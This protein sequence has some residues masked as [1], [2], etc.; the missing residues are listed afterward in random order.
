MLPMA[1]PAASDV[2]NGG[3]DVAATVSVGLCI[4]RRVVLGL[5]VMV[6]LTSLAANIVCDGGSELDV[7]VRV[8]KLLM[9]IYLEMGGDVLVEERR[10]VRLMYQRTRG[11]ALELAFKLLEIVG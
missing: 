10:D 2:V 6:V 8:T 9:S 3:E 11:S 1:T 7:L 4:G 5:A